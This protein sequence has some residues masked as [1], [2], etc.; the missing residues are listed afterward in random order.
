MS[1]GTGVQVTPLYFDAMRALL[2]RLFKPLLDPFE[3]EGDGYVYKPSHRV[4][5]VVM[6]CL[7]LFLGSLSFFLMPEGRWDYLLPLVVFGGAGLLGLIIGGL[8]KD[9]AVARLWGS[10]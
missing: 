3:K 4:I 5:L 8:G 9:V 6:S 7:F 2:R 10:R 1:A